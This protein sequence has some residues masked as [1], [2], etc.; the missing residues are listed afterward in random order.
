MN[1]AHGGLTAIDN[2]NALKFF[3]HKRLGDSVVPTVLTESGHQNSRSGSH[4]LQPLQA[5]WVNAPRKCNRLVA[6]ETQVAVSCRVQNFRV[7]SSLLFASNNH[8]V[9]S[10]RLGQARWPQQRHFRNMLWQAHAALCTQFPD[11]RSLEAELDQPWL[12]DRG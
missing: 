4:D 3:R 7:V 5:V 9:T 10:I 6:N 12:D 8:G 11:P 2:R 1:E